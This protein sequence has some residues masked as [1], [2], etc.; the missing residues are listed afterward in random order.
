MDELQAQAS[1]MEDGLIPARSYYLR[2]DSIIGRHRPGRVFLTKPDSGDSDR[3]VVSPLIQD[4]SRIEFPF[5]PPNS[6]DAGSSSPT[7][8]P[9]SNP[10][11][12][13]SKCTETIILYEPA[14]PGNE[15]SAI[16][17]SRRLITII[18]DGQ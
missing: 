5:G 12:Y 17:L 11:F 9:P 14:P 8:H 2:Y 13:F 15:W 18:P 1:D 6:S 10:V 7:S 16:G 3:S 4:V